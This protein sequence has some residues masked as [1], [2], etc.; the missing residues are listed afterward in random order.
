MQVLWIPEDPHKSSRYCTNYHIDHNDIGT[1]LH[2]SMLCF[3]LQNAF[4]ALDEVKLIEFAKFYHSK[5]FINT[6]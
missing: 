2:L 5:L 3:N 6:N 1:N 4:R